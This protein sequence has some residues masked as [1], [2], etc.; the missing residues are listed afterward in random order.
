VTL[1]D[2]YAGGILAA[3]NGFIDQYPP[4]ILAAYQGMHVITPPRARMT[5]THPLC[6]V[7]ACTRWRKIVETVGSQLTEHVA[8]ARIRVRDL[9]HFQ[10]RL[11]RKVL[12][13][14]MGGVLNLQLGRQPLDLNGLLT[15]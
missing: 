4:V 1:V 2:G 13:H 8:V 10:S 6:W 14:T 11:I 7:R 12:A 3:D 9:W 5:L 15:V